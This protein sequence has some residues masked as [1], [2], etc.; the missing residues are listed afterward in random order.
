MTLH[1]FPLQLTS[2]Q[3]SEVREYKLRQ[4]FEEYDYN[5]NGSITADELK[6]VL[7]SAVP[8]AVLTPEQLQHMIDI[9]VSCF[10]RVGCV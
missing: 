6:R 1:C 10:L 2:V 4:L 3:L 8:S 9:A 5:K 7:S